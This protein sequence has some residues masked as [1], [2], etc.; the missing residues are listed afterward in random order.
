ME[1]TKTIDISQR[2]FTL[3]GGLIVV[4]AIFMIGELCYQ[5]QSLPKNAYNEINV[6]GEG[7]AYIKPDVALINLGSHTQ[8]NKSQDAVNEN[9]KIMDVAIKSIKDL[10][11]EDKDIQTTMYN[12]SPMYDYT[13]K[14]RIFR[15]YSLDQQVSIKIRNFDK[16]NDILDKATA[17]GVNTVG[18]LRFTVDNIEKVKAEARAKAII[19]AKEK[20][21]ALVNQAGLRIEKLVNISEGYAPTPMPMYAMAGGMMKESVAPQ[22]QTGQMEID[23]TV[24]LTYRVR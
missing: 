1:E 6:S 24:T 7:K 2:L 14:G 4:I 20:A 13:E 10:G 19:Q 11:V 9:N 15:G 23:T 5:F 16:I 21:S 17:S 8:A 12:L 18:D 22:I 3:I